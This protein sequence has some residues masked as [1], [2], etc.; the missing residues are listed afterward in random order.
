MA[1]SL[2]QANNV[3]HCD[4][5]GDTDYRFVLG[6]R[7]VA[8]SNGRWRV[9]CGRQPCL[10]DNWPQGADLGLVPGITAPRQARKQQLKGAA[11]EIQASGIRDVGVDAE[12]SIS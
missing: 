3:M 4:E 8:A 10:N 11:K 9:R 1:T 2:A 12:A 5:S 6:R 7:T